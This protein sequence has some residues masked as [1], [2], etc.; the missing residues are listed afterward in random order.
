MRP[1]RSSG[2][3]RRRPLSQEFDDALKWFFSGV[4][5]YRP[6]PP[7]HSQAGKSDH[8]ISFLSA[9]GVAAVRTGSG[10]R[11]FAAVVRR[12]PGRRS[13]PALGGPLRSPLADGRPEAPNGVP[14]GHPG[15]TRK[16]P[17]SHFGGSGRV[18]SSRPRLR[19]EGFPEGTHTPSYLARKCQVGVY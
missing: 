8:P 15:A 1:G 12:S 19:I 9:R 5:D 13:L 14:L 18:S 6:I 16:C 3:H 2:V 11:S 7:V 4:W 10:S 17:Q